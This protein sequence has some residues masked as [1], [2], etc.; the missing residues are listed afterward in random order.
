MTF[1][2]YV[3]ASLHNTGALSFR[4]ENIYFFQDSLS[5]KPIQMETYWQ[6]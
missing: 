6:L 3:E 4:T 1:Q 2:A 5:Q